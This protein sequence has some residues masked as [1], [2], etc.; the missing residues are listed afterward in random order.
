MEEIDDGVVNDKIG[1]EI[2]CENIDFDENE[3]LEG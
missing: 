2:Q 1:I 3:E